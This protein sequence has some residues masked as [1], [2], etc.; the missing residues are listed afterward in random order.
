MSRTKRL[1]AYRVAQAVTIP[2]ILIAPAAGK[3]PLGT[4]R[5]RS[6]QCPEG[7]AFVVWPGSPCGMAP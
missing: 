3:I 5:L 1:T 4:R 2:T 7:A 6:R